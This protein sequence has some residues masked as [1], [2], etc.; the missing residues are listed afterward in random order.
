MYKAKIN[1][2]PS[3][4]ASEAWIYVPSIALNHEVGRCCIVPNPDLNLLN[5][6]LV[7]NIVEDVSRSQKPVTIV[8]DNHGRSASTGA[9]KKIMVYRNTNDCIEYRVLSSEH[10]RLI[11]GALITE[12]SAQ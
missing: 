11:K 5:T 9:S 7:K 2:L 4:G 1:S 12:Y 8:S 6:T 3:S 10:R